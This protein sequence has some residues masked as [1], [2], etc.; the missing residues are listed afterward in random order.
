MYFSLFLKKIAG[1]QI[2]P[3]VFLKMKGIKIK[4]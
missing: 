3:Q 4:S 2:I 1:S